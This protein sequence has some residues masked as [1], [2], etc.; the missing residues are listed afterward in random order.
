M[1]YGSFQTF[2]MFQFDL[3][4]RK[5]FLR[6]SVKD[7]EITL[8]DLFIGGSINILG[9]KLTIIDYGEEY[10]RRKLSEKKEK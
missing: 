4:T 9:R 6:T 10:T 3:K 5:V 8:P 1:S 7:N 2:Q